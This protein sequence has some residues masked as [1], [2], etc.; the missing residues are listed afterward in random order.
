MRPL[1]Y[2][3]SSFLLLRIPAAEILEMLGAAATGIAGLDDFVDCAVPLRLRTA[4]PVFRVFV[5]ID[6]W[7]VDVSGGLAE[8]CC[9]HFEGLRQASSC[10]DDRVVA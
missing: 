1:K 5:Q 2:A 10:L 3:A 4:Y 6:S 8:S 9:G 7:S